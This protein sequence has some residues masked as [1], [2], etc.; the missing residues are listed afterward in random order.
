MSNSSRDLLRNIIVIVVKFLQE[1]WSNISKILSKSVP[2][3]LRRDT[4]QFR[5]HSICVR[6]AYKLSDISVVC[7]HGLPDY[8]RPSIILITQQSEEMWDR[9]TERKWFNYG[10][11]T[12]KHWTCK[13]IK[14]NKKKNICVCTFEVIS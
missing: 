3:S 14:I 5:K 12:D 9:D 11:T 10:F 13:K 2:A 7:T 1:S 4:L 8:C 6:M